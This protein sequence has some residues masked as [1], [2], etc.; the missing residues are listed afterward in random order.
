MEISVYLVFATISRA[1]GTLFDF[2]LPMS[3]V[4]NLL[5]PRFALKHSSDQVLFVTLER[6]Q[7]IGEFEQRGC[8]GV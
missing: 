7:A 3:R 4:E 8:A 6:V 2:H 5:S 1:L